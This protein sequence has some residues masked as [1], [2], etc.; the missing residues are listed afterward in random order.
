MVSKS[1]ILQLVTELGRDLP[2]ERK[3]ERIQTLGDIELEVKINLDSLGQLEKILARIFEVGV[4]KFTQ[5]TEQ[6]HFFSDDKIW[7]SV[8]ILVR[9]SNEVWIKTKKD[10]RIIETPTYKYRLLS[11]HELK[12]TPRHETYVEDFGSTVKQQYIGSFD[13]ECIDYSFYYDGLSFTAT[14]SLADT[15][16]DSLY[17]IEFE[18]DGHKEG[19]DSPDMKYILEVFEKMLNDVCGADV[20][21][22]TTHT[23]LEWLIG[24][25]ESR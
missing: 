11:R 21:H 24:L 1:E 7:H 19:H 8:L 25:K 3:P 12:Q 6:H 22:L 16:D 9:G 13:K 14:L 5:R 15:V 2:S 20:Q 10:H 4:S 23:K 18:Y 17:Q